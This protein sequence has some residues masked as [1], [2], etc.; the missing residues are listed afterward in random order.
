MEGAYLGKTTLILDGDADP[1]D[2]VLDSAEARAAVT[3][4]AMDATSKAA[5]DKMSSNWREAGRG[6]EQGVVPAIEK[7][8]A[9]VAKSSHDQAGALQKVEQGAGKA[10]TAVKRAQ[11]EELAGNEA[12][13]A[14][15]KRLAQAEKEAAAS[16]AAALRSNKG[17]TDDALNEYRQLLELQRKQAGK[18]LSQRDLAEV[19]QRIIKRREEADAIRDTAREQEQE[20][21]NIRTLI[22][23]LESLND[24]RQ[25]SIVLMGAQTAK[26]DEARQLADQLGVTRGT[27]PAELE[28]TTRYVETL[29]R[30]V[31]DSA[32]QLEQINSVIAERLTVMQKVAEGL[33]T[34]R[35]P[36]FAER[37]RA[38]AQA[39][40][41]RSAARLAE[42]MRTEASPR[43]ES[44]T[45]PAGPVGGPDSQFRPA[46]RF[47]RESPISPRSAAEQMQAQRMFEEWT[48]RQ[49]AHPRMGVVPSAAME[50]VKGRDHPGSKQ[51]PSAVVLKSAQ[52][53]G[54]SPAEAAAIGQSSTTDGAARAATEAARGTGGR[55]ALGLG[56]RRGPIVV[57]LSDNSI[58]RM[59]DMM[60]ASFMTPLQ[61]LVER[62]FADR[63]VGADIPVDQRKY[64]MESQGGVHSLYDVSGT[65]RQKLAE[66]SDLAV[67]KA[68]LA[69]HQRSQIRN[70][71]SPLSAAHV[72]ESGAKLSGTD[73]PRQGGKFVSDAAVLD[74]ARA[75]R[76]NTR[77]L[78][79]ATIAQHRAIWGGWNPSIVEAAAAGGGQGGGGQI[80]P[81]ALGAG[82][83]G[84][85][86]MGMGPMYPALLNTLTGRKHSHGR[87]PG[88]LGYLLG[89]AIGAGAAAGSVASFAGLGTE[90]ILTTL[91][92]I[93]GSGVAAGAGAG[94]M[95]LGGL[96]QMAVGGG[97]DMAVMRSTLADTKQLG[98]SYAKVQE[99]VAKYGAQSK[100]A[101]A[102]Q[103]L[104]NFEIKELGDTAG[105]HAE[106][107]LAKA[108]RALGK[109][110]DRATSGARV[111]AVKIM[112]QVLDLG[113]T[114]VPLIA[115]AAE[116]NLSIINDRI[117]P[118]FSWM[119]GPEG[120]GIFRTLENRFQQNLPTAVHAFDQ[121]IEVLLKTIREA[122]Q[123]TGGLTQKVDA[124]LTR[125]NTPQGFAKWR[126]EMGRL[127]AT[128]RD[129]GR[130]LTVAGQVLKDLFI[131]DA[132]TG[133]SIVNTL[134]EMLTKVRE[135]EL[136]TT[137]KAQLTNIFLIHKEEVL[138]LMHALVPLLS[139]FTGIYMTLAPP[140]TKA[141]TT[142]A[143]GFTAVLDAITG[144]GPAA[145][146]IVGGLLVAMK[147]GVLI[148]GI[149]SIA[150]AFGMTAATQDKTAA[151][152]ERL[153]AANLD[154]AAS[155][156]AVA[157]TAGQ[158]ALATETRSFGPYVTPSGLTKAPGFGQ[159]AMVP[160]L[161]P[162]G[163]TAEE[164]LAIEAGGA[165][166]LRS[167]LGGKLSGLTAAAKGLGPKLIRGGTYG[168][169]GAIGAEAITSAIPGMHKD[170]RNALTGAI[171][172]AATGAAFGPWGAAAGLVIGG[173]LGGAFKLFSK[174]A[175]DYGKAFSKGF[176]APLAPML[177][178]RT[179]KDFESTLHKAQHTSALAQQQYQE[180]LH[181]KLIAGPGG[182]LTRQV[183]PQQQINRDFNKAF[184]A[185]QHVGLTSAEALKAG[186][187]GVKNKTSGALLADTVQELNHMTGEARMAAGRAM[188]AYTAELEAKKELPKGSVHRMLQGMQS[189][190][191]GFAAFMR[192]HALGTSKQISEAFKLAHAESNLR[193]T[194]GN[195]RAEWGL[196]NIDPVVTGKNWVKNVGTAMTDL[197]RIVDTSTGDTKKKAE[198]HL[199]ELE[200]K[201][202][203][204]FGR[205]LTSTKA[206]MGKWAASV[207]AGLAGA[208][209]AAETE[210]GKFVKA[211]EEAE[212]SGALSAQLGAKLIV[213]ATNAELK[214]VGGKEVPVPT[215]I[216]SG[217][218]GKGSVGSS[219]Q[220]EAFGPK[221]AAQGALMQIGN[222]GERGADNVPLNVGGHPIMVGRGEQVAVFNDEQQQVMD[223][224]LSPIG[225][226]PGLF[227]KH[228]RPHGMAGGGF[229]PGLGGV[230]AGVASVASALLRQFPG[231]S[232]TSTTGGTHAG[233]SLH[234]LGEAVDIGGSASR[235]LAG[236]A[237]LGKTWGRSLEEGIHNPNLSI[238]HGHPVSPSFWGEPTWGEHANHIHIGVLGGAATAGGAGPSGGIGGRAGVPWKDVKA[239]KV[240][241]RGPIAEGINKALGKMAHA[242]NTYGKGQASKAAGAAVGGHAAGNA[243]MRSWAKAGLQA[244]GL[245]GTPAEVSTI[246][247]T[248]SRES[249]GN[250][251]SENTTDSNARAGHPS[252]GLMELIPENFA[253]YHV[254]G[255]SSN[256]FDPVAN[257]A[258]SVRYMIARYGH[259]VGMSPYEKGGMV[260]RRFARGGG[261]PGFFKG[262]AKATAASTKP[263]PI[264][265]PKAS[266]IKKPAKA[267]KASLGHL[268][269]SL[270]A[271]PGMGG[272]TKQMKPYEDN[273]N[274][275]GT[276]QGLLSE[277][278]SN[279]ASILAED[280]S[281]LAP[282]MPPG[283]SFMPYDLVSGAE[284]KVANYSNAHGESDSLTETSQLLGWIGAKDDH[285]LISPGQS[286][287]LKLKGF[288]P[289]PAHSGVFWSEKQVLE[290]EKKAQ[291]ALA[292]AE[293]GQII[294][295]KAF[296]ATRVA[297]I[298][299]LRER[300]Q[301]VYRHYRA[302][303]HALSM[304]KL[305]ASKRTFDTTEAQNAAARGIAEIGEAI[306]DEQ[307]VP[308]AER[309]EQLI[310]N[311]R[312]QEAHMRGHAVSLKKASRAP[313]IEQQL[314]LQMEPL[315]ETMHM[316]G[317]SSEHIGKAGRIGELDKQVKTLRNGQKELT[318]QRETTKL[319]TIPKIALNIEQ[320]NEQLRESAESVRPKKVEPGTNTAG[321]E[322]TAQ[323]LALQREIN[324]QQGLAL[325]VSQLQYGVLSKLPA[326]GGHFARGGVVPGLPGEPRTIIA[327][328]GETVLRQGAGSVPQVHV[329]FA[330]GMGW[331]KQFVGVEVKRGTRGSARDAY[332]TL[333]GRGGGQL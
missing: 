49:E 161:G 13:I 180:D 119:K 310:A 66:S 143:R 292:K 257:V 219:K 214:V 71:L 215:L 231:L 36:F 285:R 141:L 81:V 182:Q 256:V 152:S 220:N 268:I 277:M 165:S 105:V 332:R 25:R 193:G 166:S 308:K 134:T 51:N 46:V 158:A 328:G 188:L 34:T 5:S 255:T 322:K 97:S 121:G 221:V 122:S 286:G 175:P 201:N 224:A 54:L 68:V 145:T 314:K 92:G 323:E 44:R 248:M 77:A 18:E 217:T 170:V 209:P 110:W 305:H 83:G 234:Y 202:H 159:R 294:K 56:D 172:G 321:N 147:L 270:S 20:A 236:A 267:G 106:L 272:I 238:K 223:H 4:A 108:G 312:S 230:H 116:Q 132:Q 7:A 86:P 213:E 205:M 247:Y 258:A 167:N 130:F 296:I 57:D 139:S 189:Q 260:P 181:P 261:V 246:V 45:E 259:I 197:R 67:I 38:E 117:K 142:I 226:L 299:K 15:R 251:R 254:P 100:Q 318:D 28:R 304:V 330:D 118:L 27:D 48:K 190:Y 208:A 144:L 162:A 131:N 319:S 126:D 276:E 309:N 203:D 101:L 282:T 266:H 271:V 43:I 288:L 98:S 124:F 232:V 93:A 287:L 11:A 24:E 21:R 115:K 291:E 196:F 233:S 289:F 84:E 290:A 113:H 249:G 153:A 41:D 315:A 76:E 307:R 109:L 3:A 78:H 42:V 87:P 313:V 279:P 331:L 229:A 218:S 1:L 136:S 53:S 244:A 327:H 204:V 148:P 242:A 129:W 293:L 228:N 243:Q 125:L 333:P 207:R 32:R 107:G 280:A 241:G 128:T 63:R 239:P 9:A 160:G 168:A 75:E 39:K 112:G 177:T 94:L 91:G 155:N 33:D 111:Q 227:A 85:G 316:L 35:M 137:G 62:S 264:H 216:Q 157:A 324:Q 194:L 70:E 123:Y 80:P 283:L 281:L 273:Y 8:T 82:G 269:D 65:E 184:V 60:E 303:K 211:V 156:K 14:A 301:R 103:K 96:G 150:S 263:K 199:E 222:H 210:L 29:N 297:R 16:R 79:E 329:N 245:P 30:K 135:W 31:S 275:L 154:L 169:L 59:R 195:L 140:L 2:R 235:M 95:G 185:E 151:S 74:Q 284:R 69:Q 302:L 58:G 120:I 186:F 73:R 262:T 178:A 171:S 174:Q 114:Y 164:Q 212:K 99:A 274:A 300:I 163:I 295:V 40:R 88:W 17:L 252:R 37:E 22:G 61:D 311:L 225:G 237:W 10:T 192:S 250:P 6:I 146:T 89:P 90:H 19:N 138:A 187:G 206:S 326:F 23:E 265:R 298:K 176:L 47:P 320:L 72:L 50:G 149:R 198:A 102:A 200:H 127:V 278:A 179:I 306:A 104:L 183:I 52:S 133:T 64:A 317:G 12:L 55:T 191:P 240:K 325:K 253:R 26:R 173:A